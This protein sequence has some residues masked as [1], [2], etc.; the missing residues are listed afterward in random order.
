[1]FAFFA[2]TVLGGGGGGGAAEV[3]FAAPAAPLFQ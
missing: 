3:G 1:M 2:S